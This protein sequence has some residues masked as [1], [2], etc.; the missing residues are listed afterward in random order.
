MPM[1]VQPARFAAPAG[2]G[3]PLDAVQSITLAGYSYGRRLFSDFAGIPY[4][5]KNA[6]SG[7]TADVVFT[8]D[9]VD[10]AQIGAFGPGGQYVLAWTALYDQSGHANDATI[11]GNVS[12]S[13]I[14]LGPTN[15]WRAD[16]SNY[17]EVPSTLYSGKSAGAVFVLFYSGWGVG[18][19]HVTADSGGASFS[20]FGDGNAYEN[21]LSTS[22]PS[23]ASYPFS[24][25]ETRL[26][27]IIQTGAALQ[28]WK[29][30]T[31]VG[32]NASATFSTTLNARQFPRGGQ[33]RIFEVLFLDRQPSSGERELIEGDMLW[34]NG[35]QSL[36]PTGHPY[37]SAAPT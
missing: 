36:L 31:Q 34:G 13:D 15:G 19:M 24:G 35:L 37:K 26:H 2:G 22:R 29:N 9:V 27:G 12:I 17:F 20:P 16:G 25:A 6:S 28:V 30:G 23:F 21:F 5:M 8:G 10:T 33:V 14:S 18:I 3:L 4:R 1:I 11:T 7:S 32:S